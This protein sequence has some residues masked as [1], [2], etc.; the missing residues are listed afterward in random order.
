M[1]QR[2]QLC[3]WWYSRGL[4]IYLKSAIVTTMV[5]ARQ[6]ELAWPLHQKLGESVAAERSVCDDCSKRRL[7]FMASKPST[8]RTLRAQRCRWVG[9]LLFR[10]PH[11]IDRKTEVCNLLSVTWPGG[12]RNRIHIVMVGLQVLSS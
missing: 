2:P 8:R 7:L 4:V 11:F 12:V 3:H 9:T 10:A 6:C 5:K 1:T